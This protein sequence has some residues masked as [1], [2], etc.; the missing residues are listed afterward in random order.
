MICR[1][2]I[3]IETR[4]VNLPGSYRRFFIDNLLAV[5][6]SFSEPS[7]V[8]SLVGFIFNEFALLSGTVTI[9]TAEFFFW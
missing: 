2:D 1:H 3:I 4:D 5:F 8:S 6:S 9:S 7:W